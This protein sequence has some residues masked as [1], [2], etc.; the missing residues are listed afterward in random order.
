MG[1]IRSRLN[2]DNFW[3]LMFLVAT[4]SG[5]MLSEWL[6]AMPNLSLLGL[7]T[8][9]TSLTFV[10]WLMISLNRVTWI[11][12]DKT[13]VSKQGRVINTK[14]LK[15]LLL[16]F[17]AIAGSIVVVPNFLETLFS[18]NTLD[19][20]IITLVFVSF[21]IAPVLF[22]ILINCPISILFNKN[23]Y[24]SSVNGM[25]FQQAN[26]ENPGYQI[27]S[28]TLL[29]KTTSLNYAYLSYNIN[30]HNRYR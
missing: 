13:F 11:E 28:P 3:N 23:I 22:F 1:F 29:E 15:W 25:K 30:N 26:F 8:L 18:S 4:A 17:P 9:I 12:D 27:P 19:R 24:R 20:F 16:V 21:F 10:P 7:V 14:S 6:T 2:R 5:I